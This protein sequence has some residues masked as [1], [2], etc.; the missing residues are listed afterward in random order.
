M[1]GETSPLLLNGK[2]SDTTSPRSIGGGGG[3]MN[4]PLQIESPTIDTGSVRHRRSSVIAIAAAEAI[5]QDRKKSRVQH[6][7]HAQQGYDS[8]LVQPPFR[9]P[10]LTSIGSLEADEAAQ[11]RLAEERNK[12]TQKNNIIDDEC[13]SGPGIVQFIISQIP[14]VIIAAGLNFMVVSRKYSIPSCWG[15]NIYIQLN[16]L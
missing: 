13:S 14:A 1:S 12:T 9:V 5:R 16:A 6:S 7:H 10:S 2:S 8:L 3:G 15:Q 4:T 11:E